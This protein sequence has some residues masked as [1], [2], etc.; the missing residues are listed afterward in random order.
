MKEELDVVNEAESNLTYLK[1]KADDLEIQLRQMCEHN[2]KIGED[3][4]NQLLQNS[5]QLK[6]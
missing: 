2:C 6:S 3:I 4:S 1:E 5:N